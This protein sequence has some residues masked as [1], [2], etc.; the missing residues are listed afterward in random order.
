VIAQLTKVVLPKRMAPPKTK[1]IAPTLPLATPNPVA[2][3]E[4]ADGNA[5]SLRN[6]Y[7]P[8]YGDCLQF[9]ARKGWRNFGAKPPGATQW[10]EARIRRD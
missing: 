9:A 4:M 6:L 8:Q 7:C 10:A 3:L 5:S 1:T 2:C